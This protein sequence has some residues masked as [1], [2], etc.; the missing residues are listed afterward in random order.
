MIPILYEANET[1]FQSNGIGRLVDCL[2]WECTEEKN[3]IFEVEFDYPITG[4]H[5]GDIIE[6]RIAYGLHDDSKVPQPFD[7]YGRSA[8][9]DGVVTFFAHHISYRLQYSILQPFTAAS[10]AAAFAQMAGKCVTPCPFTFWTDKTTSGNF[11][12]SAPVSVKEILGGVQGSI[13]DVYGKGEYEWD[14][15]TVKLHL[16]RGTNTGV[17]IRYGKNLVGLTQDVDTSGFYSAVVPFWLGGDDGST[18]VTLPEWVVQSTAA[19]G[20]SVP[21]KAVP[22]DLSD[23]WEEAPTVAQLRAKALDRVNS[24]EA[25]LPDENI[26]VDFV[27][28]WQTDEY[29]NI[30]PL[31]RVRLC[32]R[33]GV[34]D[35]ELGL[36]AE[37]VQAIKTVYDGLEERYISMEFGSSRTSFADVVQAAA[38]AAIL[39]QV[40]SKSYFQAAIDNATDEITG[41]QGGNFV[42]LF[43][44]NGKPTGFAIMDTDDINTAVNVW[45]FTAGGLGHSSNGFNGPFSDVALTAS[46]KIN[47]ELITVGTMLASIIHGGVLTLGGLD[48]GSGVIV[49]NDSSNGEIGRIDNT[50][51]SIVGDLKI[52]TNGICCEFA[53]IPYMASIVGYQSGSPTM[54]CVSS[55]LSSAHNKYGA[56][57]YAGT[58]NGEVLTRSSNT[59]YRF[60]DTLVNIQDMSGNSH[61]AQINSM[62]GLTSRIHSIPILGTSNS[63]PFIEWNGTYLIWADTIDGLTS[64]KASNNTV[65]DDTNRHFRV[66][67]NVISAKAKTNVHFYIKSSGFEFRSSSSIYLAT[68]T[69]TNRLIF[70]GNTI[71][72]E[73]SSS[74]RYKHS[75]NP[76]IKNELDPHRLYHLPVV[77]FIYNENRPL[78]YADMKGQTLPGFIAE[79]VEVVYPAA[80][81]HGLD[82]QVESW[83]ERRIIP[84]LLAL[85]QEQ[86]QEIDALTA[87]LEKLERMVAALV[88]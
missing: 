53:E 6:G 73:S 43:D 71:A 2:R 52:R 65:P 3:G 77:Q 59:Y 25:W 34:I 66:T 86:K 39:P 58:A 36:I 50:G 21:S 35:P 37:G 88:D 74:R 27:A 72:Y 20:G 4:Q 69:S 79:D 40:P 1:A 61:I 64:L 80:V 62:N 47:A 55:E 29:A 75:I 49:I 7:I 24:A 54:L 87:R 44:E 17:Q 82:G 63:D 70:S 81:I 31:E 67:D 12:V 9:I 41:A 46:G 33:V 18:L 15:F 48:N 16:N 14:K 26:K 84:G 78:Q 13:L 10:C 5:Y 38:E 8:P 23:Q 19:S 76:L 28:L 22:L 60:I 83:D 57:F 51:A 32:D 42:F 56:Y 45:R 30:A 11:S 68:D 85:V